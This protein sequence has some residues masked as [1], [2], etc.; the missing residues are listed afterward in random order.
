MTRAFSAKTFVRSDIK[1][2]SL[3]L[4]EMA[5]IQTIAGFKL[6]ILKANL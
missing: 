4:L 2:P 3:F 5:S 6:N 1:Q